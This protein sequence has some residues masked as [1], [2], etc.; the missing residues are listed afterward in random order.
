MYPFSENG[1]DVSCR[2]ISDAHFSDAVE[3]VTS[4]FGASEHGGISVTCSN[5]SEKEFSV[6][7]KCGVS[8]LNIA[9]Y[10]VLAALRTEYD[11]HGSGVRKI[12]ADLERAGTAVMSIA[13]SASKIIKSVADHMPKKKAIEVKSVTNSEIVA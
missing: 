4:V 2:K 9:S 3:S 8:E 7:V 6:H 11:R 5:V 1:F 13:E 10:H 12:V